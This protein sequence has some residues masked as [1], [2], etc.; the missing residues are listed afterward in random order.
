MHTVQEITQAISRLPREEL[1]RFREWFEEFDA[2]AWDKQ[3]E[4]DIESGKLDGF[5]NQA[6]ADFYA[7]KCKEL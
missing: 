1:A 6:M 2:S 5:A 4:S 7:G 3:I